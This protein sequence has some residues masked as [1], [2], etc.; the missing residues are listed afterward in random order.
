[1]IRVIVLA[2][3]ACGWC[4]AQ[5]VAPAETQPAAVS[6]ARQILQKL[7]QHDY[8]GFVA[9][10]DEV[11]RSKLTAQHTEQLWRTLEFKLGAYEREI[12]AESTPGDPYTSVRFVL[13]FERGRLN[14]R[15]VL[16]KDNQLSGW[17]IDEIEN[18][19]AYDPP[20]YV[21][22]DAFR[23]E[24]M[25]VSAGK[26]ELPAKL[27][28]PAGD[29]PHSGLVLVHGSG[30]NDLDETVGAQKPFRDL[31]WGLA[32]RGVAVLR[33]DKRT[34]VHPHAAKPDE[35]TLKEETTED[36]LAAVRLL[37]TRPEVADDQVFVLGH[38]LGGFAAP[39]I[40]QE[41]PELRGLILLAGS[42]RSILDLM[43]EQFA[44]LAGLDGETTAAE[45]LQLMQFQRIT[46]AIREGRLDDLPKDTALPV[47]YLAT[48]HIMDTV[49]AA[50][51]LS[52]P[53]LIIHGGR[54]YQVAMKDYEL[55]QAGLKARDNVTFRLFEDLN[56]L[57]VQGEGPSKPDEYQQ[58]GHVDERIIAAVADWIQQVTQKQAGIATT[59]APSSANQTAPSP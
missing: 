38:S 25:T 19:M 43:E 35:W 36:A 29:G 4:A 13:Q 39:F 48:L 20:A 8:A 46:K 40:G 54:D 15:I 18:T 17:W 27:C 58:P 49:E 21:K 1:M 45:Q 51:G 55:W 24:D 22:R 23:E 44:Y 11:I 32:S 42:A 9:A 10:G 5:E 57:F 26:F 12:S 41:D 16:T 14:T 37:R 2:S 50:A 56:H 7:I 28:L 6:A 33:Y 52:M 47:K 34:K 3:F 53:M 30:P 59:T 31:A